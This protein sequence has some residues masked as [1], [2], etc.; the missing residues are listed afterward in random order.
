MLIQSSTPLSA[1][2][3][4]LFYLVESTNESDHE[5]FFLQ[6]TVYKGTEYKNTGTEETFVPIR[7]EDGHHSE[8]RMETCFSLQKN[9]HMQPIL[10]QF[11]S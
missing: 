1:S 9:N 11:I 5:D 8:K 6:R 4:L 7:K 10:E 2:P 3:V